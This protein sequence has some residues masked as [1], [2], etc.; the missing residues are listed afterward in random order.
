MSVCTI[1]H[2]LLLTGLFTRIEYKKILTDFISRRKKF[3]Q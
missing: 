3:C 2:S 1:L